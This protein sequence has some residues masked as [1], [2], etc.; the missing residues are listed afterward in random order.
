MQGYLGPPVLVGQR[1][2]L[3]FNKLT[4]LCVYDVLSIKKA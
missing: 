3:G 4:P 2:K 1:R